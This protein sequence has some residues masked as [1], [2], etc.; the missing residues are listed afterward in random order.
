MPN[1]A[2]QAGRNGAANQAG[3]NGTSEGQD[4]KTL[5]DENHS[6]VFFLHKA[7]INY[8]RHSG[9]ATA[10]THACLAQMLAWRC[11]LIKALNQRK[12]E[13]DGKI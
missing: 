7:L 1:A 10:S 3:K 8:R 12:R 9:N 11:N 4:G 5:G 2:N 6:G 13:L